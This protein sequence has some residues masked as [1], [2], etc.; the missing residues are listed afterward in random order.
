MGVS[1]VYVYI[2]IYE[3]N[4]ICISKDIYAMYGITDHVQSM[5]LWR[6]FITF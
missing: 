2:F 4:V 1:Y 3:A 5:W 6:E